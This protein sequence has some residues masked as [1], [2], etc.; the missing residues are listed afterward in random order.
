MNWLAARLSDFGLRDQL[1]VAITAATFVFALVA[2]GCAAVAGWLRWQNIRTARRWTELETRWESDVLDLL[3]GEVDAGVVTARVA[4]ADALYFVDYLSRFARRL[5]GS[6][7]LLIAE[8]AAPY[9]AS[10]AGQ[11]RASSATARA[12]AVRTLSLLGLRQHAADVIAALDDPSPLVAMTAARELTRRGQADFANAVLARLSRFR[13][14]SPEYLATMLAAIGPDAAAPLRAIFGAETELLSVRVVAGDALRLLNNVEAS[15][16]AESIATRDTNRELT[17]VALRLLRACGGPQHAHVARAMSTHADSV[18]RMHACAALGTL[19]DAQ[20]IP[21]LAAALDDPSVWVAW[22]AA[23]AL[24][25]VGGRAVLERTAD[26]VHPRADLAR[27][28]LAE[29]A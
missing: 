25:A 10:A 5:R 6:E 26:S 16:L 14:W 23:H 15:G 21:R 9:L 28:T 12:R 24:L 29:P 22:R 2:A 7:R 19:G 13:D 3:G 20:D 11:L 8:V 1:F 4:P 17:S 18:V 27:E